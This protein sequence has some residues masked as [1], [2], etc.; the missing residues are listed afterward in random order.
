MDKNHRYTLIYAAR[1]GHLKIVETLLKNEANVNIIDSDK[2]TALNWAAENGHTD[3]VKI[4]IRHG[5]NVNAIDKD[6]HTALNRAAKKGRVEIIKTLK[7]HKANVNNI[8]LYLAAI[9][10]QIEAVEILIEYGV[11][12]NSIVNKLTILHHAAIKDHVEVV[13]TLLRN[14]AKIDATDNIKRTIFDINKS[15]I[16]HVLHF[17]ALDGR[18]NIITYLLKKYGTYYVN[19]A[20]DDGK[21]TLH[22]SAEN[23]HETIVDILMNYKANISNKDKS[24]KTALHLAAIKGHTAIV[25]RLINNKAKVDAI[26]KDKRTPLFYAAESGNEK[27][28]DVLIKHKANINHT[29]NGDISVLHKA[30]ENGKQAAVMA[31]LRSKVNVNAK[32]KNGETALHKAAS[33]GHRDVVKLLIKYKADDKAV[34]KK[35]QTVLHFAAAKG[36]INVVKALLKYNI[37]YIL[38]EDKEEKTP[39]DLAIRQ[40]HVDKGHINTV[41]LLQEA[42]DHE[43]NSDSIDFPVDEVYTKIIKSSSKKKTFEHA[44]LHHA[45]EKGDI[46]TIK[47]LIEN[48]ETP[49]SLDENNKTPLHWAAFGGKKEAVNY[50]ISLENNSKLIGA[51]DDNMETAL[52][53]AMRNGHKEVVELLQEKGAS[54]NARNKYGWTPLHIAATHCQVEIFKFM[55]VSDDEYAELLKQSDEIKWY[56]YF[57]SKGCDDLTKDLVERFEVLERLSHNFEKNDKDLVFIYKFLLNYIERFIKHLDETKTQFKKVLSY[58]CICT[59]AKICKFRS[60]L[61]IDI[62]RYFDMI[63][64]NI[65]LLRTANTQDATHISTIYNYIHEN[66]QAKLANYVSH[67]NLSK[68]VET[69]DETL[70]K[71]IEKLESNIRTIII[72]WHFEKAIDVFNQWAFPYG[73]YGCTYSDVLSSDYTKYGIEKIIEKIKN[74]R[75]KLQEHYVYITNR[76]DKHLIDEVFSSE[77]ESSQP[78]FVWENKKYNE[79]I[80]KLLNGEEV[81]IIADITESSPEK[82]AIKFNEIGIRLKSKDKTLQNEID[83]ELK[84]FNIT[85]V[86][87]GKSLY[88]YMNK[89]YVIIND[90][91]SIEYSFEKSK[92]GEPVSKNIVYKKLKKGELMFSPYTKWKVKI[93]SI[94][95]N[96]FNKL[97]R[98]KKEVDLEL[99]GHGRY[100]KAEISN[101]LTRKIEEYYQKIEVSSNEIRNESIFDRS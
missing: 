22:L 80:S 100:I 48:G 95:D 75:S 81:I 64:N 19:V 8:A 94:K 25:K 30:S 12:V 49:D 63:E 73:C 96:D 16:K 39:L 88:R 57:E 71:D 93:E 66:D 41:K 10:G 52:Y 13:K 29:D 44:I 47:F 50:L 79:K 55:N 72:R 85:M 46:K 36:R 87:L 18:E 35:G 83:N 91:Q 59:F 5:A 82:Y 4:L 15:M 70:K 54:R 7:K 38:S 37:N 34:D 20:D 3:V 2:R 60:I 9:N 42:N 92:T 61:I 53:E 21:T 97:K 28:I 6:E 89:F 43:Q 78:F 77:Y 32:D 68:D 84:R 101:N 27:T 76:K 1:N 99:V 98:F 58:L 23:G 40:R 51:T 33:C 90:K 24:H 31:L 65:K 26:D 67:I 56:D 62:E 74:L 86:H 45:A 11:N 14:G 17:A 69:M